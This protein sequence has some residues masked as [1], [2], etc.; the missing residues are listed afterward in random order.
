[1]SSIAELHEQL[2]T[3]ATHAVDSETQDYIDAAIAL[4]DSVHYSR[5]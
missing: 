3:A 1:M 5:H 4:V 2:A